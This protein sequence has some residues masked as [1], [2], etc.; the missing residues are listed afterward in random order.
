MKIIRLSI[1]FI[2]VCFILLFVGG[3]IAF[4]IAFLENRMELK[5]VLFFIAFCLAIIG[6]SLWG[7]IHQ[8]KMM[9]QKK[10]VQPI[11]YTDKLNISF[12]SQILYK[13][14]RDLMLE[15]SFKRPVYIILAAFIVFCGLSFFLN[16]HVTLNGVIKNPTGVIIFVIILLIIPLLTLRQVKNVYQTNKIFHEQL[17]Y[18]LDNDAVHL[19]SETIDS[20]ILWTRFHKIKET[21][22]FFLLYSDKI[23]ANLLPKKEFEDKEIESFRKLAKSLTLITEG[24]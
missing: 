6:L 23:V 21:K 10:I 14:Y 9:K 3:I 7:L 18:T 15:L 20:T 16:D 5:G 13:E 19:K 24:F 12:K 22:N 2:C 11:E 17:N 8:I 1:I 4:L